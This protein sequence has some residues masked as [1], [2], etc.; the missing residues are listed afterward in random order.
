MFVVIPDL[1]QLNCSR[2]APLGRHGSNLNPG[3]VPPAGGVA[4]LC[5]MHLSDAY[6]SGG[7]YWGLPNSMWRCRLLDPDGEEIAESFFRAKNLKEALAWV[8]ENAPG[9]QTVDAI[10]LQDVYEAYRDEALQAGSSYDEA[11]GEEPALEGYE[12]YTEPSKQRLRWLISRF[13]QQTCR[14]TGFVDAT[15]IGSALYQAMHG[16]SPYFDS[17]AGDCYDF[18]RDPKVVEAMRDLPLTETVKAGDE[19]ALCISEAWLAERGFPLSHD[20]T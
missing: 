2:G 17:A 6:D 13:L 9:V 5:H 16:S 8:E 1:P 3:V 18:S 15:A 10:S 12:D 20:L 4:Q 14:A 7:A 19:I 11:D